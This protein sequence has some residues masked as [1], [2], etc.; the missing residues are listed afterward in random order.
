LSIVDIISTKPA[1]ALL[2]KLPVCAKARRYDQ[3]TTGEMQV[4][5]PLSKFGWSPVQD[6]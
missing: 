4:D 5:I 1:E 2:K 6:C 3:W